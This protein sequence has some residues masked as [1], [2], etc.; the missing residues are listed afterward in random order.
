[1]G[2]RVHIKIAD[3]GWILEKCAS[4]IAKRSKNITYGIAED[5]TADVQYYNNYSCYKQRVSAVEVGYFTHSEI[6]KVARDKFF[7]VARQVEHCVSH[8][9]RYSKELRE[10]GIQ[11]VTT[12]PPGV[13]LEVFK[14]KIR[15][16][17]IGR[18]Y[19]TGRK[20][21]AL[22]AQVMD[23][24][25]I[26]WRFTGEGWPA[27]STHVA[28]ADM[29]NF[30]NGLDYVL[31][32]S[33]YE[34]GPMSVA[35]SLACGVPVIGSDVGWVNEFP[36][37]PFENGNVKS[38]RKVLEGLVEQRNQLRE[39]VLHVTWDNWAL[40]HI[41]L[42]DELARKY[43]L[44]SGPAARKRDAETAKAKRFTIVSHGNEKELR[45]GP[46]S[47]IANIVQSAASVGVD[48]DVVSSLNAASIQPDALVHV[49]NSWP[50]SSAIEEL[51]TASQSKA[52][53]VYSP[54]ALN[55]SYH[56]YWTRALRE[57]MKGVDYAAQL[58]AGVEVVRKLT[59]AFAPAAG[60]PP[61]E[62]VDGHFRA[63]RE[64]VSFADHVVCL[65]EYE[66][67][68][69]HSIGAIPR[70]SSVIRN[71]VD[72]KTMAEGDAAAFKNQYG[73]SD[74]VL[75]VGRIE[76][77]KNQALAA[78]ALKD[79]QVPVVCI[80]HIGDA[81][82]FEAL[83]RWAGP[84]FVHIDRIEN[85]QM[86]ASAFKAAS[87]FVL[88]S[89]SEGAPLA[90]LEAAAAGTPLILSNMAAEEEYFGSYAKYVHPCDL[91]GLRKAVRDAVENPETEDERRRRSE[92]AVEN[93]DI[94][95]HTQETLAL[96]EQMTHA[97]PG[98]A[99]PKAKAETN[100]LIALDNTHL[101]HQVARG[102]ILTGVPGVEFNISKAV[103]KAVPDMRSFTWNGAHRR[104]VKTTLQEVVDPAGAQRVTT[105]GAIQGGQDFVRLADVQVA[106]PPKLGEFGW[107]R[108]L[109]SVFKQTVT[110]LPRPLSV[111]ATTFLKKLRP[112]FETDVLPMHAVFAPKKAVSGRGVYVSPVFETTYGYEGEGLSYGERFVML[113]QPWISNDRMLNDLCD[114]VR[115]AHL[116]LW[117]FVHDI[118]YVLDSDSF[119][120]ETRTLFRERLI[121]L[122]S[123]TDT[124]LI[125]SEQG[126]A[127][128]K[129]FLSVNRL[130]AR[131]K[132]I[133]LG[134]SDE[135]KSV[136]P[137]RPNH[138]LPERFIMYVSSMNNRKRHDFIR[139]VWNDLRRDKSKKLSDV[140]LI[141]VGSAQPGY[142]QYE[143]AE[144]RAEL[145]QEN[146]FV[147]DNISTAELAWM[148]QN[149]LFTIYPPRVEGWGLPPIES[150]YF[151]KPC[152][153]TST[154]PSAVETHCPA[155]VK[156]APNDYFGWLEAMKTLLTNEGMRQALGEQARAYT[157]PSWDD[158]AKVLLSPDE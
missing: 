13:D 58:E 152:V 144:F 54:I 32:P 140:G 62:G 116:K 91:E 100:N 156:I 49:F 85:R 30:Y 105:R 109:V 115:S 97:S 55:L 80:G 132:R 103:I 52:K 28:D 87:C 76:T 3:R 44:A 98:T 18:T 108:V 112:G 143:E 149:C 39:S 51:S 106:L 66:R 81:D 93:F 26:E 8:A 82:Y 147:Y 1:M 73:L 89:W 47:R 15:I 119:P 154:L 104:F 107:K 139:E 117:A 59:P 114:L 151:G 95:R 70:S 94:S 34:G 146:I 22:V 74:F 86:L 7:A 50:L 20:G 19:H 40:K 71:G 125:S 10:A 61:S 142:E 14:P 111:S 123:V 141:F 92:M 24:P 6:D 48:I 121:K 153:I 45:G 65:S 4:E 9:E 77:R 69:L 29:P 150:L 157:P 5:P 126:M 133:T 38:L 129:K 79:L 12:I 136:E 11:N 138:Q 23:I 68:F 84:N 134:V 35:E 148:Y 53:V 16:G 96:Y 102:S 2:N 46:T 113:G 130:N 137:K 63:L 37:I 145:A 78:Y 60:S 42:F 101:A 57:I 128:M 75:M 127:D 33:L 31:V 90:A 110:S 21:E 41:E 155:L 122:L 25:E 88:N 64:S 158:V 131:I 120:A 17:V 72:A 124:V 27:P 36:H 56:P 67:G 99:A 43:D 135:I 83:K 118:L